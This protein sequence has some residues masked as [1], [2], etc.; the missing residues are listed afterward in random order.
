MGKHILQNS[1]FLADADQH[2]LFAAENT[3]HTYYIASIECVA[4]ES[5]STSI[6]SYVFTPLNESARTRRAA[7]CHPRRIRGWVGALSRARLYILSLS[8]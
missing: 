6:S 5:R 1:L 7:V 2:Y 8:D 3:H 4:D